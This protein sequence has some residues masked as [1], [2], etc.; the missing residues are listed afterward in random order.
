M[1]PVPKPVKDLPNLHPVRPFDL[2]RLL[3]NIDPGSAEESEA[4]VRLIYQQR[5]IG[6]NSEPNGKTGR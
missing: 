2:D 4:Y 6:V 1:D 3:S 5:R